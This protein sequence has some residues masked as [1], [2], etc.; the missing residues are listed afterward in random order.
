[1][2]LIEGASTASWPEMEQQLGKELIFTKGKSVPAHQS[3]A[4]SLAH[5][6]HLP[7]PVSRRGDSHPW[8]LPVYLSNEGIPIIV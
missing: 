5:K 3:R 1:M 4:V 7:Q 6:V 8:P 2:V